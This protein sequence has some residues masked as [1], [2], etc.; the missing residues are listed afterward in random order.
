M[1]CIENIGFCMVILYVDNV[2]GQVVVKMGMEYVIEIVKKNGVVV[3]GISRMGYSGVIFYFVCQVVCEGLIGLFICQFD[4]MVVLFGGVDIYYGIN[5][6]VFVVL[7]EGDDIII[8]DMVII[9]QVWGKVFDVWFCNEFILESWVVDKNGVLIYDFF[10]VNVLLFVV[11][12]KGYGLMMMI[13]IL[14]G[15]LLGLL[16]GCQVSLMYEDL[17]VG[18]NLG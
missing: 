2:V 16:F 17:Y 12:L 18:C 7:G 15:I 5:L 10:V 14:F 1:F 3:V 6:L 11:G 8:F 9:V 4:F 13:D